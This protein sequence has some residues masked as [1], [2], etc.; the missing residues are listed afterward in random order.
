MF[1][2]GGAFALKARSALAFGGALAVDDIDFG[3][4][5][6]EQSSGGAHEPQTPEEWRAE[7][8]RIVASYELRLEAIEAQRVNETS[9]LGS[10][11]QRDRAVR[12]NAYFKNHVSKM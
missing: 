1:P 6:A 10:E 11:A 8:D 4:L 12:V 7:I 2:L 5:S 9:A 3:A